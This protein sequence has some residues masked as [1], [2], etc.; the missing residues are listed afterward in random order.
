MRFVL[1]VLGVLA[2]SFVLFLVVMLVLAWLLRPT[3]NPNSVLHLTVSGS[4]TE[5]PPSGLAALLDEDGPISLLDITSSL[6]HAADDPKIVGVVLEVK[7]PQL[8]VAQLQEIEAA[9]ET[10]RA[11]GKWSVSFLETAGVM[12][13]GD[14]AYALAACAGRVVLAPPGDVNFLGLH[15]DV[16][17]VKGTL[18]KLGIQAHFNKRHQHKTAANTFTESGFTEAHRESLGG[19]L[20]DLQNDL[21]RHVAT[22]RQVEV[23][24]VEGWL[25]EGPHT[26]EAALEAGLVDALGYWDE[27]LT[28]VESKVGREDALIDIPA[29]RA[30]SDWEATGPRVALIVGQGAVVSGKSAE[31]INS[32]SMGSDTL[33][34]AFRDARRD[35]VEGVLFRVDSPGGS[36]V[37]SDLIRREV[38]QTRAAGIPVVIS[39]G[40]VAASGGYLVAMD[41]DRIVAQPGTITGSIG[42]LSGMF[43]TRTFFEQQLGVTF[44]SYSTAPRANLFSSL[45]APSP[46]AQRKID[47]F[48]DRIYREFVS[49]AA[50][51]RGMA[52]DALEKVARGRVWSGK[53]AR[54]HRLVDTLGGLHEAADVLREVAGWDPNATLRIALYPRPK[55]AFEAL[56]DLAQI[57]ALPFGTPGLRRLFA[58]LET[59]EQL[60]RGDALVALPLNP[61]LL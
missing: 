2:G 30:G 1:R 11:A 14:G 56:R 18:E 26:A 4:P 25:A 57:Q 31:G 48:L 58:H 6:R 12:S 44:D 35:G 46:E 24:D 23:R 53:A 60:A 36:Y 19:L 15:A 55:T 41:A 61:Y 49:K 13:R 27:V 45:D 52:Y 33:T 10:V 50:E 28:D 16:P 20:D 32:P 38:Q 21:I 51:G 7:S 22:R 3:V 37:A 39:M 29:Y 8:S 54:E 40:S 47:A 9:F 59:W 5:M 43:S 42:V 17:F 34:Q